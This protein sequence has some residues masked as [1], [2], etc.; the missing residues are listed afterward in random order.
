MGEHLKNY[1]VNAC[2]PTL[3]NDKATFRLNL[4]DIYQCMVTRVVNKE[5]ERIVYYHRIITEFETRPK[6][7]FLVKCDTF[8]DTTSSDIVK[9]SAQ[10]FPVYDYD[11]EIT[12]EIVGR[13]PIPELIVG[14]K[15]DGTL[16]DEEL[17]VKP[18]TPLN[19]EIYLDRI[20]ADIY[21][22]MVSGLDVTDTIQSQESLIVNGCTVDPVLFENFLTEDGDLLRAKF[23]AFKFP[24]TNFVLFKGIVNVCLDRC[25]GVQCSNGQVG[26]G[27]R[28]KRDLDDSP[29]DIQRVYE[30]SMSTIVKV[31]DE[32]TDIVVKDSQGNQKET[33][34]SEEA[35]I[36]EIYHPEELAVARLS[37]AF[38][39]SPAKYIDFQQD[40][41]AASMT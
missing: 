6:E 27:R 11:I 12:D 22:L 10:Q 31:G 5:T 35:I 30:V 14:V 20:S 40:N 2:H 23:Q 17:T 26:F 4:Q 34:V 28:K 8:K 16:I 19:M 37:E 24:E 1:P 32:K 41:A 3:E 33:F 9:R 7:V 21:G 36:S 13:A 39:A 38:G 29:S 18:G 15:Q 25:N